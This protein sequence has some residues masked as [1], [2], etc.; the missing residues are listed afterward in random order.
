MK[1]L[2]LV[3]ATASLIAGSAVAAPAPLLQ[4]WDTA[5]IRTAVTASGAA[6][7]RVADADGLPMSTARTRDGLGIAL[8][9]KACEA[10]GTQAATPCHGLEAVA[11][12][13]PGPTADRT[14][15]VA[16]LNQAYAAGKFIVVPDGTIRLLR[17][18]DFDGG[19]TPDNLRAQL[20]AYFTLATVTAQGLWRA[21]GGQ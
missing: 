12:F 4:R 6:D 7:I 3:F 18:V 14:A 20:I 19:V 11:S 21:P 2:P 17:Y 10:Q 8:Y 16:K 13:D 9:P 15:L 5:A 1:R